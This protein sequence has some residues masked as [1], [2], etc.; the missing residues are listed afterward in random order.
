MGTKIAL[1]SIIL[2]GGLLRFYHLG[3]ITH[4]VHPD[5]ALYLYDGFSLAQTGTD[6]R[7]TGHPP[8][9][10]TGYSDRWDNRTSILYPYT[11][12][13]L[14]LFFSPTFWLARLPAVLAAL[15]T[16][17][18]T[19]A[20]SRE[21]F[22]K[23]PVIGLLA[24]G[25]VALSPTH[26]YL[27]RIGH[28][29]VLVPL[30]LLSMLVAMW[31]VKKNPRWWLVVFG[32]AALGLYGYQPFKVLGPLV[33]IIGFFFHRYSLRSVGKYFW[34]GAVGAA[35][36]VLPLA[37][38]QWRSWDVVQGEFQVIAVW[39]QADPWGALRA[40]FGTI[41]GS[42]YLFSNRMVFSFLLP[43]FILGTWFMGRQHRRLL[44]LF[45]SL[46]GAALLPAIITA[47]DGHVKTLIARSV[48]LTGILEIGAAYGIIWL[49]TRLTK[50]KPV[51]APRLI[52]A[53]LVILA[54]GATWLNYAQYTPLLLFPLAGYDTGLSVVT[55][56]PW[57][58]RPVVFQY[59]GSKQ[60]VIILS[61]L[62]YPPKTFLDE[63]HDWVT[64]DDYR[65]QAQYPSRFGRYRI[66]DIQTCYRPHDGALYVVGIEQLPELPVIKSFP[67]RG[68]PDYKVVDNR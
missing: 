8:F 14:F 39:N 19:Y 32:A 10:L 2:V 59:I 38:T 37:I 23:R 56:P 4:G 57:A 26:L 54:I 36:V 66:C 51:W 16:I 25:L 45:Y 12:S 64:A 6:H 17:G 29:P 40:N 53:P 18:L 41:F 55:S 48:G 50:G 33:L 63:P 46:V 67:V 22:P 47:L 1:I 11:L 13:F 15:A 27:S 42:T 49:A 31:R 7:Q 61:M 43:F 5:E 3:D 28:D 60:G 35:L 65:G 21:L 34:I 20:F 9:Y 24:A 68:L 30:F 62:G 52:F 58:N 44:I